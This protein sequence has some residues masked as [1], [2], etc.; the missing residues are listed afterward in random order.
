MNRLEDRVAVITGG[1]AGIGKA[2]AAQLHREGAKVVIADID[3]DRFKTTAQE[4]NGVGIKTDVTNSASVDALVEQTVE[5]FGRLDIVVN[6]AG[7]HIQKLLKD[8]DNDDWNRIANTNAR[9]CFYV[10]R[11]ATPYLMKREGGRIVNIITRLT[12]NPFSSA[13]VASKYAVWGLTQC[14]ALELA[15]YNVT[16]NAVAPGHIGLGTGMEKWFR[17]KAEL[18]GQDWPTFEE[19][20]L[21]SIPLG[22]WCTPED[23]ARAVAFLASDEA[24]FITGE[25]INVT[26]GW[27]GYGTTPQ[28]E[29]FGEETTE[30]ETTE[31][32]TTEQETTEQE[33][34][35]QETTGKEAV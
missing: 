7:V 12:G 19:N 2:V 3:E 15:P 18:L 13:Y 20:V 29:T 33:T 31:Q 4:L 9:G 16:V 11:A 5:H 24:G 34:T 30:Q 22:R 10:C 25:Q 27:T 8:L 23:V 21:K 14:L 1:A 6:N 17:A 32:E 26:G 28:K 35:E